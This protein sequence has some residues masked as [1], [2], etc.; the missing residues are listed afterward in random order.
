[1]ESSSRRFDGKSRSLDDRAVT[2]SE[3]ALPPN[4]TPDNNFVLHLCWN[5][6]D[7]NE[8][9]A[10]GSGTT[11][12]THG[13]IIQEVADRS[14]IVSTESQPPKSRERTVKPK[15]IDIKPYNAKPKS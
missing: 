1:M 4:I 9:T 2:T 5:N 10:P 7:L 14:K 3:S 13:I 6:F 8:E 12:S 11:H 15:A